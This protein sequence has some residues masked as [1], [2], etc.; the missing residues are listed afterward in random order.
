M[1]LFSKVFSADKNKKVNEKFPFNEAENTACIT[2]CHVIK[3]N[4]PILHVSH[5]A[6]DGMWQFL[7]GKSHDTKEAMVISLN[8]IYLHDLSIASIANLPLGSIA[9][10]NNVNSKWHILK[11]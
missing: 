1:G 9:D 4:K 11:K 7:C 5:D 3:D 2:C 8:A 10:R 6:N